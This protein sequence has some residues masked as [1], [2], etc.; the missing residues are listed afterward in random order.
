MKNLINGLKIFIGL[1]VL[2]VFFFAAMQF[3]PSASTNNAKMVESASA[4]LTNLA[5]PLPQP[6][7]PSAQT[8]GGWNPYPS[9]GMSVN[10]VPTLDCSKAGTLIEYINQSAGFSFQYPAEAG[11]HE[12]VENNGYTSVQLF[13]RPC[14]AKEWWGANQVTIKILDN[15]ERLNIEKFV[16]KRYTLNSSFQ[17]YDN[18][19]KELTDNSEIIYIDQAQS[20]RL[21]GRMT[22][23]NPFV[24]IS[25]DDL[26]IF[27][28]LVEPQ[29]VPPFEPAC[30]V[31]LDLFDRIL[32][33]VRF[34]KHSQ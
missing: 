34:I 20:L 19:L 22:K 18:S 26:V 31:I 23:E 15:P 2:A 27:V 29:E 28:S 13:L 30:P 33:S 3:L 1:A 11:F 12:S 8:E 5:Y 9:P 17:Q 4:T 32:T 7:P 21:K 24:Y 14:Y 25:N 10:L 6:A 16:T